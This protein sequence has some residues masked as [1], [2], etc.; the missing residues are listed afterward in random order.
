[1]SGK[2]AVGYAVIRREREKQKIIDLLR[3][4]ATSQGYDLIAVFLDKSKPGR[5]FRTVREL[6]DE[7]TADAVFTPNWADVEGLDTR[8]FYFVNYLIR[9]GYM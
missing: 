1:M 9:W 3:R 7:G 6:L 4:A 2:T 8:G 5:A